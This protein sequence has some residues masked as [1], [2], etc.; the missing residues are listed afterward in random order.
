M[1][2]C[3]ETISVAP[4]GSVNVKAK[5]CDDP[6][7]EFGVTDTGAGGPLLPPLPPLVTVQLPRFDQPL[8]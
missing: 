6:L 1:S 5:V 7:L 3:V 4:F 2:I 8:S